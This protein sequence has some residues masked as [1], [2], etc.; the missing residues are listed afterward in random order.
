MTKVCGA[1]APC[2]SP[3][4]LGHRHCAR[5]HT[6]L[7]RPRAAENLRAKTG[8]L[9]QI[10]SADSSL[11]QRTREEQARLEELRRELET[12]TAQESMLP[13]EQQRL[14]KALEQQ[15]QL[16]AQRELAFH[17]CQLQKEQ[18]LSE[19]QK[20]C[21]M[22][23]AMLGLEFERVGDERLRLIFTNIDERAPSRTFSFQVFVDKEDHY[24]SA[25]HAPRAHRAPR[26]ASPPVNVR[27]R[28]QQLRTASRR[29]PRSPS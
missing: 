11:Q 25:R 17:Q 15:R 20:G 12:L 4:V 24:H 19:L 5:A 22:Y 8:E 26:D 28:A 16:L 27:A 29:C 18:K 3:W 23:R 6:S 7:A 9:E 21:E 13:P 1:L 14:T 2:A 10:S